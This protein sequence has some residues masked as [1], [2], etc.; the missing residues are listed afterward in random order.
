MAA[1]DYEALVAMLDRPRKMR[2]PLRPG[3]GRIV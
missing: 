3:P 1:I 2:S